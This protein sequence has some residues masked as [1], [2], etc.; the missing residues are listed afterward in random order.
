MHE[1]DFPPR[2]RCNNKVQYVRCMYITKRRCVCWRP[3]VKLGA[4]QYSRYRTSISVFPWPRCRIHH[5]TKQ[6]IFTQYS[7]LHGISSIMIAFMPRYCTVALHF[8]ACLQMRFVIRSASAS[9]LF[10]F[11]NSKFPLLKS[12]KERPVAYRFTSVT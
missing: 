5:W 12:S 9:S 6:T 10:T 4:K 3:Q 7:E 2:L 1:N 8:L 11:P